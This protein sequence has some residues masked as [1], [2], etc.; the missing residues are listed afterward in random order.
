MSLYDYRDQL[1]RALDFYS[2]RLTELE[3]DEKKRLDEITKQII[4]KELNDVNNYSNSLGEFF[5][6]NLGPG[7]RK[8][9]Q[10][11]LMAYG[12]VLDKNKQ[13]LSSQL[14]GIDIKLLQEDIDTIPIIIDILK[15]N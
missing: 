3:K 14:P 5:E 4:S 13:L 8:V 12:K 9:F 15:K 1:K 10:A 6:G 7:P 2:R 11:A